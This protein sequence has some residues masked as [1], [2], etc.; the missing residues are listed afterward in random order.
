MQKMGTPEDVANA[1]LFL[2]ADE[3]RYITGIEL[4]IDGGI[5]AGAGA[6]P[7]KNEI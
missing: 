1:A 6:P 5:L 7:G 3:S 2:A 4:T